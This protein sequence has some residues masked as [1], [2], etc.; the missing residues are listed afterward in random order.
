MSTSSVSRRAFITGAAVAVSALAVG[1][2]PDS[3]QA[4]G[5]SLPHLSDKD[6]MAKALHYSDDA[7]TMN[8]AG[9]PTYKPGDR[10]SKCRFFEGKPNERTGFAGC[11]IYPGYSVSA[12]G[13]CASYNARA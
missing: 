2:K 6:P 5:E 1:L 8:K 7:A 13:W 3:A 12:K 11:Q 9:S 4:K 10:C